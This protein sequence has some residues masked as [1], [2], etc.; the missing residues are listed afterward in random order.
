MFYFQLVNVVNVS[1]VFLLLG[2]LQHW[3]DHTRVFVAEDHKLCLYLLLEDVYPIL[4][5]V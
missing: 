2:T 5:V 4:Q 3:A 1:I